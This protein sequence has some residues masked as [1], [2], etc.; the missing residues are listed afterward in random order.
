VGLVNGYGN[1]EF[2][3]DAP[4]TREQL[5]AMLYRYEQKYGGGFTGSWTF[6][7]DFTDRDQIS[8]WAH[9]SLCWMLSNNN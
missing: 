4:I 1:G 8:E 2:G 5:A 9:E 6:L 3:P 7:P